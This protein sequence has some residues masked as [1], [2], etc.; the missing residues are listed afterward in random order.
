MF[1]KYCCIFTGIPTKV[2][3][4][5]L[6]ERGERFTMHTTQ[7]NTSLMVMKIK[8]RKTFLMLTTAHGADDVDGK[9]ELVHYYNKYMN[10]VD[11]SDQMVSIVVY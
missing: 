10:A 4:K 11:R 2:K 7:Q 6:L 8:D 3:E 5:K 9:P 1:L